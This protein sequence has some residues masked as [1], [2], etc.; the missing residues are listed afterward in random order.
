MVKCGTTTFIITII[1]YF[2]FSFSYYPSPKQMMTLYSGRSLHRTQSIESSLRAAPAHPPRYKSNN[3]YIRPACLD[4]IP[5]ELES[6]CKYEEH[7]GGENY[8]HVLKRTV[9]KCRFSQYTI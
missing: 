8:A 7:I 6:K 5:S 9:N 2:P 1:I 3:R 4:V